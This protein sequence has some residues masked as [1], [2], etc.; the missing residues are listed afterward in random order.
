MLKDEHTDL[1]RILNQQLEAL[2][3]EQWDGVR[4]VTSGIITDNPGLLEVFDNY[5]VCV[6]ADDVAHESRALKVD[7]DLSIADPMLALL[8]NLL[9]WMKILYFMTLILSKDQNMY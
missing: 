2:P 9:V 7:I 4:V 6:V 3:E 1:L 8:I 5:K